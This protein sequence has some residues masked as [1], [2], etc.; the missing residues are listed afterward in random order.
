MI[1]WLHY[2]DVGMKPGSKL[3]TFVP[4]PSFTHLALRFIALR[5]LIVVICITH[6]LLHQEFFLSTLE[7][8]RILEH[9][10][11]NRTRSW[12]FH[13][14]YCV[15]IC[16]AQ[17]PIKKI[18]CYT[19]F[20]T[21]FIIL[22]C[23]GLVNI[24]LHEPLITNYCSSRFGDHCPAMVVLNKLHGQAKALNSYSSLFTSLITVLRI[25]VTW[26]Q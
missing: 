11:M 5:F 22:H 25:R 21:T 24:P 23:G 20:T 8:R 26:S 3:K 16:L 1:L 14:R 19:F 7:L 12:L 2:N 9:C 6:P 15:L 17:V 10:H 13:Y 18:Y 4:I